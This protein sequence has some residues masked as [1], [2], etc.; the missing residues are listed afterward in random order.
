[1]RHFASNQ[2]K[3]PDNVLILLDDASELVILDAQDFAGEPVA[4]VKLDHHITNGFHGNWI[5]RAQLTGASGGGR[6]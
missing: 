3:Q 4:R 5:P 6:A 2:A 1:M